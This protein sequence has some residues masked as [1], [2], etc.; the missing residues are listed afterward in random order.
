VILLHCASFTQ[1]VIYSTGPAGLD[2]VL[3]LP[4]ND[5]TGNFSEQAYQFTITDGT[6]TFTLWDLEVPIRSTTVG[7]SSVTFTLYSEGTGTGPGSLLGSATTTYSDVLE[8]LTTSISTS[9]PI[10]VGG[11]YW[12]SFSV[13]GANEI[14][15]RGSDP[16]TPLPTYLNYTS[17]SALGW[18]LSGFSPE[19]APSFTLTS[20]VPEPQTYGMAIGVGLLGLA[21]M[22]R[23]YNS[24]G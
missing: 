18:Q 22:R 24:R 5:G 10:G 17:G 12:L 14:A 16:A 23:W 9:T 6:G 21:A 2:D 20:A 4:G 1:A 8:T 11:T 3:L 15:V 7:N 13:S 19:A